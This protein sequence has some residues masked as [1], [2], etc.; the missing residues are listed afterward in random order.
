[1]KDTDQL[2]K[3]KRYAFLLLKFRPRSEKEIR[4]RL[5]GK[6]FSEDIIEKTVTFLREK[7]FLDDRLFAAAWIDYRINKPL[8]LRRLQ[9]ELSG[10]GIDKGIIARCIE[11]VKK[12]YSEESVVE[13]IVGEK[14]A[15]MR[16]IEV[17]KAK[18]RIYAYLLRRGFSPYVV[19]EVMNRAMPLQN[20]PE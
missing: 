3:A 5:R 11:E 14:L 18:N 20:N 15:R 7:R 6:R 17:R 16:G 2:Y 10:K 13:R 1:M 8:G 4:D 9:K 12:D 19:I